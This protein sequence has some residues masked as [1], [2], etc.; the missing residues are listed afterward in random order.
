[1]VGMGTV[2]DRAA[3]VLRGRANIMVPIAAL[4]IFLPTVMSNAVNAYGQPAP[5]AAPNMA[6]SAAIGI[7]SLLVLI[8]GVWGQLAL[9]AVATDPA[10]TREDAGRQATRRI[11]PALGVVL[12]LLAIV[13]LLLLPAV[14]PLVQA[15]L[16]MNNPQSMQ[17]LPPGVTGFAGLYFLVFAIAAV[18]IGARLILINPVILNERRGLGAIRRSW[19]LTRG[20]TW[21]IIGVML[22]FGVL[23]LIATFAVQ[24]VATLILRLILGADSLPTVL[25]VAAS[26]GAI[27]STALTVVAN[28]FTAQLYVAVAGE[29]RRL[30]DTFS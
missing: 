25:F 22:L 11:G 17:S 29:D 15:G 1:M 26:L 18:V 10:T 28:A 20:L 2:W 27:V 7:V 13:A 19:S 3:E 5:G 30:A 12:V 8:A 14:V 16:D 6:A 21:R 24:A 9:L 23:V 4:T